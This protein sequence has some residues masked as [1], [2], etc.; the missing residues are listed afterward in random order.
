MLG[1]KLD[2]NWI[3]IKFHLSFYGGFVHFL[4]GLGCWFSGLVI[5]AR[6]LKSMHF[7]G[8]T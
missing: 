5:W 4:L 1:L 7:V 8:F 3:R 2:E 6:E